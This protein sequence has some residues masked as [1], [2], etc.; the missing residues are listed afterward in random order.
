MIREYYEAVCAGKETR[1]NL[2]ALRSAVK[3]EKEK[4]AFAYLLG[5]DFTVLCRLLEHEDPKV[6][7]NAA[8]LLGEMESEDVL[9]ILFDAYKKEQTLFVRPDYLKA[10]GEMDCE[11]YLDEME[12]QLERLRTKELLPEEKKHISAEMRMLQGI[13]LKHRKPQPHPFTGYDQEESMLLLVNREQTRAVA[14][15]IKEGT[16]TLLKGGIRI[17]DA[18]IGKILPVR[19]Y[20]ELLFPIRTKSLPVNAPEEIGK[21]LAASEMTDLMARLHDGKAPYYF[22]IEPKGLEEAKKGVWIRKVSDALEQESQASWI[23]SVS[24]Y[25]AE[26]RLLMKKDGTMA[27]FL[28][29]YTIEDRRFAYRK[30]SIGSSMKPVNAALCVQLARPWMKEDAQ[31]LDPFCGVGTLLIERNRA[32]DAKTMYGLDIFGDAIEKA[33]SNTAR[34][35]CRVNYIQ[36]DFFTFEHDYLFDEIITD[37]PQ[38]SG[39]RPKEEIHH[40]YLDFFEKAQ[41]HLNDGGI[42]ILYAAYPQYAAEAVRRYDNFRMEKTFLLNEKTK[43]TLCIARYNKK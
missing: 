4:R 31:I 8:L 12:E 43:M 7:K 19:T 23:N 33:K 6:R 32:L 35:N 26:I 22:R 24:N 3:D 40:L 20:S 10:I 37:L 27:A 11:P 36:R 34:A 21:Q 42:V 28:R 5:G 13:L 39:T 9:P 41:Q 38:V 2:I 14:E 17:K 18:R 30:E 29:L 1:A 15:G 25:E 16:H